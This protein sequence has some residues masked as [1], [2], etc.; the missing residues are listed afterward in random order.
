MIDSGPM[1]SCLAVAGALAL[2]VGALSAADSGFI[3]RSGSHLLL[4]GREFRFSGANVDYVGLASDSFGQ[5]GSRDAYYPSHFMVDDAFATIGRMN[6]T[7]ARI[8][9]SASHGCAL[10]VE[11]EPGRFNEG[12]LRQ[13]DYVVYSASQHNVRLILLFVDNWKYYTGGLAQYRLWFPN[14]N[15]Y[16][17]AE[18]R[19]AFKRYIA[20]LVNRVNTI[21]R[22]AYRDDP[23]I[24]AWE[25][26]NEL[27]E[28]TVDWDREIAM[29]VKS[30]DRNHLVL[31]GNDAHGADADRAAVPEIDIVVKHYYPRGAAPPSMRWDLDHDRMAAVNAGKVFVVGEFGWDK[32]NLRMDELKTR[33]KKIENTPEIAGD[34][35]WALRG[36]K[37]NKEFMAVPGPRDNGAADGGWWG[38]TF[39]GGLHPSTMRQ[40]CVLGCRS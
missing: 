36:R 17:D 6:G 24:M 40:R 31:N 35:Y 14:R 4:N 10:C 25:T 39:R 23:T 13:L 8:W 20:T 2:T 21:T 18:V 30:I 22:T 26:G 33:L 19:T 29:Y 5:I 34:L 28:S 37:D 27:R 12:A 15:F 7:V 9:S 1:N 16:Q 11:P 38:S 32:Q 3:K